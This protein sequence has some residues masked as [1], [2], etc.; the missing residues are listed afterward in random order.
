MTLL[1]NTAPTGLQELT[2]AEIDL[3]GWAIGGG[4]AAKYSRACNA[5][6]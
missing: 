6:Q 5:T 1:A 3:G 2:C 4:M